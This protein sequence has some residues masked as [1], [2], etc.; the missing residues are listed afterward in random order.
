MVVGIIIRKILVHT[1]CPLKHQAT[2]SAPCSL[3]GLI[4]CVKLTGLRAPQ[5][6]VKHHGRYVCSSTSQSCLWTGSLNK[7]GGPHQGRWAST[8][9]LRTQN[10]KTEE[11]Q[12]CSLLTLGH[13]S[14][15]ALD[16]NA[17]G[18]QAFRLKL[19]YTPLASL[20]LRPFKTTP[21]AFLQT[22]SRVVDGGASQASHHVSQSPLNNFFFLSLYIS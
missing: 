17:P 19:W 13:L 20:A 10:K 8:N 18:S 16:V 15:P 21:P 2:W 5:E 3:W 9:L 6:L 7:E 14:S 4:L 11:G 12:F 22:S 1:R